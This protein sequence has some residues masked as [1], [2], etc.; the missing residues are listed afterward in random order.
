[1][2]IFTRTRHRNRYPV[3]WVHRPSRE[4][5]GERWE[6]D[7]WLQ[8]LPLTLKQWPTWTTRALSCFLVTLIFWTIQRRLGYLI[9]AASR[10]ELYVQSLGVTVRY[11]AWWGLSNKREERAVHLVLLLLGN[12][13][14]HAEAERTSWL[15]IMITIV[16]SSSSSFNYH[17]Q[18][19][20]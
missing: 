1:M 12:K 18:S 8:F 15:I 6:E 19:W 20:S 2:S 14:R 13:K 5:E 3:A 7:W 17:N 11:Y 10:W 4:G 9:H 16:S